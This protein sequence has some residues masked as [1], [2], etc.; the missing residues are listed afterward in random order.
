[1]GVCSLIFIYAL[2]IPGRIYAYIYLTYGYFYRHWVVL[3]LR[4]HSGDD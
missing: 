3:K 4:G 2:Y 1:M